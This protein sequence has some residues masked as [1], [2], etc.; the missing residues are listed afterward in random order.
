MKKRLVLGVLAVAILVGVLYV[1]STFS[2]AENHNSIHAGFLRLDSA[3]QADST[4]DHTRHERFRSGCFNS[5]ARFGD[6]KNK[7]EDSG[8][9]QHYAGY[10]DK[11]DYKLK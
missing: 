1:G 4:E 6:N 8:S 10:A 3:L 5:A 9:E 2:K 11:K 7:N